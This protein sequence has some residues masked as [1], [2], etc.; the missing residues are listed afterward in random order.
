MAIYL[1][2]PGLYLGLKWKRIRVRVPDLTATSTAMS[3]VEWP[4]SMHLSFSLFS[5]VAS[6]TIKVHTYH[7]YIWKLINQRLP[8]TSMFWACKKISLLSQVSPRIT[9]FRPGISGWTKSAGFSTSPHSSTTDRPLFNFPKMGP[10]E[11]PLLSSLTES[12]F[13]GLGFSEIMNPK[14][15]ILCFNLVAITDDLAPS[16]NFQH[17]FSESY[18]T[19]K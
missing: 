15:G 16:N 14:L 12:N 5:I 10:G 2:L 4:Y 19:L 1:S 7:E 9:I 11:I 13:P 3:G 8:S 17:L 18:C 6:C